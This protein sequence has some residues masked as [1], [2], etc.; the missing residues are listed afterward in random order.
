MHRKPAVAGQFYSSDKDQL[1]R[2]L[3]EFLGKIEGKKNVFAVMVPHAG[4]VYSGSVA[5]EVFSK[6]TIPDT[7]LLLGPNHTGRGVPL[8]IMAEGSWETPLGTVDI[9]TAL[10]QELLKNSEVLESDHD[11]HLREHS[12]EVEIPFLQMLKSSFRIIPIVIGTQKEDLLRTL[13]AE[14]ARNLKGKNVLIVIS[15][16]M[17]HYETHDAAQKKDALAIRAIEDLDETT[18]AKVVS[19][20][21]ISMCGYAPAYTALVAVKQLGATEGK[22]IR[23]KTSGEVSGDYDKVVGYAGMVIT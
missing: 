4:Y 15:S 23:Y 19:T 2:D 6:I 18:L 10:A 13:G 21:Q 7:V 14:I 20:H 3:K 8:S 11:A 22:L 5:G 17:T 16:D 9:D 1:S 12:L